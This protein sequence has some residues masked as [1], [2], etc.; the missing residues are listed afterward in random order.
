MVN[1]CV[2]EY[3]T[4]TAFNQLKVHRTA[5]VTLALK[6]IAMSYPAADYDGSPRLS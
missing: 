4:L 1:R 3:D 5:P 2:L 6:N